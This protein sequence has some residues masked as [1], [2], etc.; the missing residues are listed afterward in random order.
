ME[1]VMKIPQELVDNLKS[2]DVVLFIGAGISMNGGLPGWSELFRPLSD[3]VGYSWPSDNLTTDHLLTVAQ[4]YENKNGRNALLS[5]L[6]KSLDSTNKRPSEIHGLIAQLPPRMI[7]TTNYDDLLE[8]TYRE[9]GQ[10]INLIVENLEFAFSKE[11]DIKIVKLCG[12]ITRPSSIIVT[13]RDFNIFAT[14]HSGVLS[15]LRNMLEAKT[16]L[17]LGYSLKDPFINQIWDVVNFAFGQYQRPGY[18]VLFDAD[19]LEIDDLEKRNLHV[20]NLAEKGRHKGDL[21]KEWLTT[22]LNNLNS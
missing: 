20:I 21:L 8:R 6:M 2:D 9:K 15:K 7:F 10:K 12:D 19:D 11:K 5:Y 18:C 1:E 17:F 13:K 3:A 14:S 16:V 22:I 4:Y